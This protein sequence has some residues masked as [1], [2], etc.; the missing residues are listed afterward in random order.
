MQR[1]LTAFRAFWGSESGAFPSRCPA[2]SRVLL[3]PRR[4]ACVVP[5]SALLEGT[6][7]SVRVLR[8]TPFPLW[9]SNVFRAVCSYACAGCRA[10]KPHLRSAEGTGDSEAFGLRRDRSPSAS[11]APA[12]SRIDE[13]LRGALRKILFS[14]GISLTAGQT[15]N[16]P[17]YMLL[18]HCNFTCEF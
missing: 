1:F 3:T 2:S 8:R 4:T 18:E 7:A 15:K 13:S 17:V 16:T 10:P 6:A 5:R 14:H 9:F 12:T 11:L